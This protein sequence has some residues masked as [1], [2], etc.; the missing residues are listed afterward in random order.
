[1][2][3]ALVAAYPRSGITWFGRAFNIIAHC[4]PPVKLNRIAPK[5]HK[6]CFLTGQFDSLVL[7]VRDPA[8]SFARRHTTKHPFQVYIQNIKFFDACSHPKKMVYFEELITE[9]G[10]YA[11]L[12]WLEAPYTPFSDFDQEY[13]R[14]LRIYHRNKRVKYIR[15]APTQQ[16]IIRSHAVCREMLGNDIYQK[17]LGRYI[18]TH[19]KS[20]KPQTM[21]AARR[22]NRSYTKAAKRCSLRQPPGYRR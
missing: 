1:M 4:P 14:G 10:I 11:I 18:P 5:K 20:Q 16:E 6:Q 2:R 3:K 15:R 21:S 17:Y 12:D 19:G 22:R 7:L 8:W 13:N 9:A